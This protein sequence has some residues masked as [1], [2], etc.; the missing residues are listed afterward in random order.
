MFEK[1]LRFLIFAIFV[2]FG[3]IIHADERNLFNAAWRFHCGD[4]IAAMHENFFDEHWQMID[5]PHDWRISYDSLG[6]KE[7]RDD[8]VGW[9]RK[10]FTIL[11]SDTMKRV[12]LCFERI[13]EQAD[14]WVNGHP[15]CRSS[16]GYNPM[17]I[18]VTPYLN[19]PYERNTVAVRVNS[20]LRDNADYRGAGIT[21]DTWLMKTNSIYLD[22]WNTQIQTNRVYK[23]RGRWYAD[24]HL[25]AWIRNTSI[26]KDGNVDVSVISPS[27]EIVFSK[28]YPVN[29][30]DS[31]FFTAKIKLQK[32]QCWSPETTSMYKA[33]VRVTTS[34]G[35]SD[36]MQ[37]PFGI[38]TIEYTP[39]LGLVVNGESVQLQ[40]STLD[41]NSR[42]TGY[43]AF[44]RAEA[45]LV[46][47]L[48]TNGYT[49]V[50]CP[51]GLLSEHF[52]TA[53]DTLGVMVLVDVF[54]PIHPDE[55]WDKQAMVNNVKR[56]INHPSITMWCVDDSL[57]ELPMI[58]EID[59]SRPIAVTDILSQ[60]LWSDERDRTGGK[61]PYA[62]VL[63]AERYVSGITMGIS[64]PD[65]THTDSVAWLAEEQR[66]T[67][68]G[69]EGKTMRVNVYSRNDW[70]QLYLNDK[71]VGNAKP[72]K[73]THK[74]TFYVPYTPGK[75]QASTSTDMRK[76]WK[77]K[78]AKSKVK[79]SGRFNDHFRLF[80]EG[81]PQHFYLSTDR[82]KTSYA[83]GEL[84]FVSIEVL[85]S[86]GNI[87]SDAEVPFSLRVRGPGIVVAAGN[88]RGLLPSLKS[89]HTYQ[90]RAMIVIRPF[91]SVGIIRVT[92]YPENMRIKDITISVSE[93]IEKP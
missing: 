7:T 41:Y 74:T 23:T 37:I 61:K 19:A 9:Y 3:Q 35:I 24:L 15:I 10:T 77:P 17:K 27:D 6:V 90:G 14:I 79:L 76:L 84:C 56:F 78:K 12:F 85:D 81:S 36:I 91:R 34:E 30:E 39:D 20:M 75:L 59:Q 32:P 62:Y 48:Q 46:E 64:A 72:D 28:V 53:C 31:T 93:K 21:H 22:E 29:L 13:H 8:N 47:H 16:C 67:W 51:M 49:A 26:A 50:R 63:D 57:S 87:V 69:Y 43:T 66:W 52:L 1:S 45:L 25:S 18:D 40:G 60:S 83:N 38:Q 80:T 58:A 82:T 4:I 55:K 70:V 11:P 44:R 92:A 33:V 2:S 88:S 42:M 54:R 68:P 71:L 86:D 89:L 73:Q 5:L 65:T